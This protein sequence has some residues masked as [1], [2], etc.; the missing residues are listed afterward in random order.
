MSKFFFRIFC[1]V[2]LWMMCVDTVSA[3]VGDFY[4]VSRVKASASAASSSEAKRLA[5]QDA[6]SKAFS[7]VIARVLLPEDVRQVIV[8]NA[9]NLEKFVKS[10][11][12]NSERTTSTGYSAE[13]DMVLDEKLVQAYLSN[14]GFSFLKD[15]LPETLLVV[16]GVNPADAGIA[17]LVSENYNVVRY[18]TVSSSV[19]DFDVA[20][21]GVAKFRTKFPDVNN[22]VVVD[23]SGALGVSGDKKFRVRLYDKMFGIDEQFYANNANFAENVVKTLNNAY[24]RAVIVGGGDDVANSGGIVLVVPIHSMQ[25]WVSLQDKISGISGV[26]KFDVQALKYD[27][28]QLVLKYSYDVSSL[29]AALKSLGFVVEQK[30]GYLCIVR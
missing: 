9:Y 28:A 4:S 13:V 20:S 18:R 16:K 25:D 21:A 12:I 10:F 26:K 5:L 14:Q 19:F 30:S 2:A 15:R 23:A 6:R 24:K 29:V 3:A 22:V 11:R 8:P 1:C 7:S 27:K 17:D